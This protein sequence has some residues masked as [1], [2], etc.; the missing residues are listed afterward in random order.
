MGIGVVNN[1][2]PRIIGCIDPL[3]SNYNPLATDPCGPIGQPQLDLNGQYVSGCCVYPSGNVTGCMDPQALNYNPSAAVPCSNCCQYTTG[4][5]GTSVGF[6]D[7]VFNPGG[8]TDFVDIVIPCSDLFVNINEEGIVY[9]GSNPLREKCCREEYVGQPVFWDGDFCNTYSSLD[10]SL[11]EN[12]ELGLITEIELENRVT[13]IDCDNFAWWDNLYST[14]NGDS[15]QNIDVDLW[16]YLVQIITSDPTN[17]LTPNFGNGSFYVDSIT[18]E[19][20]LNERCCNAIPNSN[21]VSVITDGGEQV[22][23]CLCNVEPETEL[24]CYCISKVDDFVKIASTVEGGPLLLNVPTLTSL[25]LTLEQA[26]FV[27]NN[28]FNPNDFTG[29]SIPDSTNAK[30]LISNVLYLTGGFY[31]CFEKSRQTVNTLIQGFNKPNTIPRAVDST[32]CTD[33]GGFFDGILCYCRPQ[34]DC[35][36]KLKD[37]QITTSTDQYNQQISVVTFNGE[38]LSEACCLKLANDNNLPWSYELYNGSFQCFTK[39]PNPCLPLEF[40]LNRDLIKPD[41]ENPLDVSISFYFKTPENSCVEPEEDDDVIIIDGEV[42]PCLLTFD[43]NNNIIDYNSAV[44]TKKDPLLPTPIEE[45]GPIN[46]GRPCCFNPNTPI[47]TQLVIKDDKNGIVHTSEPFSFTQFETWFDLT[48]QFILPTTGTTEGYNVSLQF[49][50]GLNC[51]CVYDIFLDNFKFNCS[52][53]EI[54]TETIKD[55]CPGF[56]IVPVI[57]N[58]KSWVYNPGKLNYSG[59]RNQG[60]FLTDNIIIENGDVGLIAG[61]GVINRTFAPSPDADI[62]WRYTDYFNQSSVLEKHSNLVLNSKELYL[63]FDMCNI[64]GPCPDSYTLSAGTETCYKYVKGCPSGYTLSAGTCYS[65]ITTATTIQELVTQKSNPLACKTKFTL[66]QL[67]NYKKTFQSFWINFVE[68]F[69]P[70]T[71]IFVAG[72]KWCNRPDEI[73]TQYEECD[74]DFEFVEGDVTVRPN[75]TE[76]GKKAV[77]SQDSNTVDPN[78]SD[79]PEE[80]IYEPIQYESTENGPINT[81]TIK[82]LP[83]PKEPGRTTSTPSLVDDLDVRLRRKEEYSKKLQ[84]IETFA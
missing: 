76:L 30:I 23:A 24:D 60:G 3:A 11:C 8:A 6:E 34:E 19:P 62:P 72:E 10:G 37:V 49:T 35:S 50:S 57:D 45:G 46:N 22:S 12:L 52:E 82:I 66:L 58:K 48:T 73:C 68:Q 33:L 14:I 65:G 47:Q 51:C 17:P 74:F 61:H 9:N 42:D 53:D 78:L 77:T 81:P 15:L 28:L 29:D 64:G 54:I 75:T 27:I 5:N 7:I 59:I 25:G 40:N 26:N 13:C 20:I 36:L 38:S 56:D 39:D 55:N 43:E 69:V 41:C 63:T 70:A 31:L 1:N 44:H 79:T 21:F 80:K 71:T 67:E 32:R 83:I 16:D 2:V 4:S 84:P 18:G